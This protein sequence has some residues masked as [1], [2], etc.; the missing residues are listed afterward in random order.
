MFT[1][2]IGVSESH[3]IPFSHAMAHISGSSC[4]LGQIEVCCTSFQRGEVLQIF[5]SASAIQSTGV[6][7]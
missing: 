6:L 3:F 7:G 4:C 5:C 1:F 2:V